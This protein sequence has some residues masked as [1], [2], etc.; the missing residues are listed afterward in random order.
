[1]ASKSVYVTGASTHKGYEIMLKRILLLFLLGI[2]CLTLAEAAE[3][4]VKH[5]RSGFEKAPANFFYF[6]DSDVSIVIY[7]DLRNFLCDLIRLIL[8]FNELCSNN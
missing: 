5:Y 7:L 8:F 1:M 6:K 4:D 2:V 3:S